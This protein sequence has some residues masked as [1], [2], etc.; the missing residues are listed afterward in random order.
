LPE[1]IKKKDG[2]IGGENCY[3]KSPVSLF[4]VEFIQLSGGFLFFYETIFFKFQLW[5]GGI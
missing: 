4:P 2:R 3:K 1:E 5:N